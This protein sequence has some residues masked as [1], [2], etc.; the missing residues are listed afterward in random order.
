VIYGRLSWHPQPCKATAVFCINTNTDVFPQSHPVGVIPAF[1]LPSLHSLPPSFCSVVTVGLLCWKWE[2]IK[3][4][5]QNQVGRHRQAWSTCGQHYR[6]DNST[7]SDFFLRK[8]PNWESCQRNKEAKE[9]N[10]VRGRHKIMIWGGTAAPGSWAISVPETF[11]A[12]SSTSE[13]TG[14]SRM[15]LRPGSHM[16]EQRVISQMETGLLT[17]QQERTS[18]ILVQFQNNQLLFKHLSSPGSPGTSLGDWVQHHPQGTTS[19]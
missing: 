10:A 12:F 3:L 2:A 11:R 18:Y 1:F 13:E 9:V 17:W 16:Q 7:L 19:P 14:V 6:R 5:H 15:A 8:A 4:I